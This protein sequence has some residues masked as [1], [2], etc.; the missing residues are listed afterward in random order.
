MMQIQRLSPDE[1]RQLYT[2]QHVFNSVDFTELNRIKAKELHYLSIHDK[3]HR[4][5]II[6]GERN[7]LLRSPFSAPFGGFT[8]N[9]KQTIKRMEEAVDLLLA[10][11][12][13]QSMQ[14]A[15]TPQP[16]IYDET[17][18][19]KWVSVLSR[20]MSVRY[21]DLNYYV[22]LSRIDNYEKIIDRS[23]K[24]NLH[25]ALKSSFNLIKLCSNEHK[26]VARAY[27]VI[28]H[29][30]EE[31]NYP[32][33]MTLEQV[34]LTVKNVIKSDFFVL[35]H[36]GRDVAAAQVFHVAEGI[37]QVVYWGDIREYSALRPMNFLT[38]SLFLYYHKEGL[39][40]LDIGPSTEEGLPNYGLCEFK[41][42]I[43][44]S[45]TLKYCFTK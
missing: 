2:H 9:G 30:R 41:E 32:L 45:I 13:K 40:I 23:A 36:K 10:Y 35:E 27:E 16:L 22:D 20:K 39:R 42:N 7:G 4:F 3:K 29:N 28:R 19:S 37:A 11:A 38:Y 17:Q 15:I 44:C 21:I 31:H 1:Y 24:K 26:E 43:G 33:R 14:L 8:T 12:E 6:L 18:L 25:N 34:W 5:G